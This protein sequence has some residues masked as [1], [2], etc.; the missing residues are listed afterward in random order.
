MKQRR[1]CNPQDMV[2][3][4]LALSC[5]DD[6]SAAPV[7]RGKDLDKRFY[8]CHKSV[9]SIANCVDLREKLES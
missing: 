7:F 2:M 3:F 1:Y 6:S 4:L 9:V 8:D 5:R